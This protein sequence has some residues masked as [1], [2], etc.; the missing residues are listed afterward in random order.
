MLSKT[1]VKM[2]ILVGALAAF[3]TLYCLCLAESSSMSQFFIRAESFDYAQPIGWGFPVSDPENEVAGL[4]AIQRKEIS[5]NP[6]LW[7][8]GWIRCYVQPSIQNATLPFPNMEDDMDPLYYSNLRIN[9]IRVINMQELGIYPRPQMVFSANPSAFLDDPIKTDGDWWYMEIMIEKR[10]RTESEIVQALRQAR[11]TCDAYIQQD[12]HYDIRKDFSIN[13]SSIERRTY[14]N[15]NNIEIIGKQCEKSDIPADDIFANYDVSDTLG[16]EARIH[17]EHFQCYS[18]LFTLTNQSNY[19]ICS[20]DDWLVLYDDCAWLTFYDMEYRSTFGCKSG[21]SI[22]VNGYY[23]ILRK[24]EYGGLIP[25][26]AIAEMKID[27]VVHTEFAGILREEDAEGTLGYDG[28]PFPVEIKR[29][30]Q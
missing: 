8:K 16:V 9:N 7:L 14:F 28:I 26:E 4:T 22:L 5:I 30:L 15:K 17:P 3:L 6:D 10:N 21:E 23:L 18:F 20:L 24:P 27:I 25:E 12:E 19:D 11:I 13:F 1:N 2:W 29:K